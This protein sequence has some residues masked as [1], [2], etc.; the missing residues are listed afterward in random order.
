[1]D[2]NEK[3][4]IVRY[5]EL[6]YEEKRLMANPD[7]DGK[8]YR[9]DKLIHIADDRSTGYLNDDFTADAFVT[10]KEIR[11][12]IDVSGFPP[13]DWDLMRQ[14]MREGRDI[15]WPVDTAT[16]DPLVDCP[17]GWAEGVYEYDDTAD[18]VGGVIPN[19]PSDDTTPDALYGQT[20]GFNAGDGDDAKAYKAIGV[21]QIEKHLDAWNGSYDENRR[22]VLRTMFNDNSWPVS[23]P[24]YVP[25]WRRI[26]RAVVSPVQR[27]AAAIYRARKAF[28]NDDDDFNGYDRGW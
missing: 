10:P 23:V 24:A 16:Y 5:S 6:T 12:R 8:I 27:L 3:Y 20:Y 21:E 15:G 11:R 19:L 13:Y 25:I 26:W 18:D 17:Y 9:E 22:N 1:L 4:P 14:S 7:F 28:F 2:E